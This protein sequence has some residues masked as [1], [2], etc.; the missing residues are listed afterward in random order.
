[1]ELNNLMTFFLKTKNWRWLRY[2]N[3]LLLSVAQMPDM[4]RFSFG[5]ILLQHDANLKS[6]GAIE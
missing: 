4:R 2:A 6:F 3:F 5:S 1:M